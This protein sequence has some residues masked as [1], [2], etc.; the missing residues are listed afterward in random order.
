MLGPV[1][2]ER[3]IR[4]KMFVRKER[5]GFMG[6]HQCGILIQRR[7][8]VRCVLLYERD[9]ISID[10]SKTAQILARCGNERFAR[11]PVDGTV[12]IMKRRKIPKDR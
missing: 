8:L 2:V 6:L 9:H 1:C 4:A 10:P 12:E 7:V 5:F 11:L 3:L